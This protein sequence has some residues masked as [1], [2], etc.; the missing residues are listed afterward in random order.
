MAEEILFFFSQGKSKMAESG[1]MKFLEAVIPVLP[2]LQCLAH[3]LT[4]LGKS[5]TKM[6]DPDIS[7]TIKVPFIEVI[8]L[9]FNSLIDL[10]HEKLFFA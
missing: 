7:S 5:I 6:L 3:P 2:L 1:W 8:V 9:T 4:P 10:F